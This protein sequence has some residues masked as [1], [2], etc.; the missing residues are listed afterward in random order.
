MSARILVLGVG[1]PLLGD[2]GLGPQTIHELSSAYS[3]PPDVRLLDGGT[4][5]LSLLSEIAAVEKLLVVDAVQTGAAPGTVVSLD[6]SA[7]DRDRRGLMG[8]HDI[9]VRELVTTARLYGG[10]TETMLLGIE[11]ETLGLG[12]G[13]SAPVAKSLPK[14]MGAV[15]EQLASWGVEAR[16]TL[17]RT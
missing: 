15:I 17:G 1:N 5:G 10:P 13:L 14:L 8:P 12:L 9:G 11:P 2:E 6:G 16:P 4:A 7:L 3:F